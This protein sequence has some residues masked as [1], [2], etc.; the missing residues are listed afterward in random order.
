[1][2]DR[3]KIN[4]I[5]LEQDRQA[6][7]ASAQRVYAARERPRWEYEKA[8]NAHLAAVA[9]FKQKYGTLRVGPSF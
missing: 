2:I 9:A 3:E 1:M 8:W 4:R 7:H 5:E 6:L